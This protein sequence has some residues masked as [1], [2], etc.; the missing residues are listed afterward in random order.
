M[1][2]NIVLLGGGGH[3][4]SCIEI[5]EAQAR[6]KI[7]GIVD[8]KGKVGNTVLSYKVIGHDEELPELIK[9][10]RNFAVTLGQ[11]KEADLRVK[12]FEFL[13]KMGA[14]FPVIISPFALI[15]KHSSLGEG[16]IVFHGVKVNAGAKI[17]R[18]CIINT[19]AIIE[20]DAVIEDHC[21]IST[22]A[23]VNGEC[24]I[25][26][27]VMVGSGAVLSNN[28]TIARNSV[29]GAGAVVVKNV[30]EKGIYVGVPAKKMR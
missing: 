17:G 8:L 10:Y 13:E 1:K 25:K 20:H 19:G 23:V 22:G 15:S 27:G 2:D 6:Y 3:C 5:I 12:K 9:K 7:A 24:L 14:S 11:V 16:T 30:E 26:R 28:I 29:I 21:H 4:K 18:N